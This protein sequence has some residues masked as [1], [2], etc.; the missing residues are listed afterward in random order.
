MDLG[1]LILLA[2]IQGVTEFLPISSSGH[3]VLAPKVFGA[4]DQGVLID[5]ALHLG[6]LGAVLLYFWRDVQGA[7]VGPFVLVGDLSARR[8]LSWESKLALLLLV[9]TIPVVVAGLGLSQIGAFD[10]IRTIEVIGWTTL[11]YGIALYV[12]DRWSPSVL[13]LKDW[14]FGGAVI[15]GLSQALALV[16]GTSRSGVCM[17]VARFLGFTRGHDFFSRLRSDRARFVSL[18]LGDRLFA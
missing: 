16:P 3:L 18:G 6:S 9:A 14:S 15:L 17:T 10:Q 8:P 4:E 5:V 13:E 2:I 11:L 7:V 1:Q 12:A